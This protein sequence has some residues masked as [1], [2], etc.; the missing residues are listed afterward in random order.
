MTR[1]IPKEKE[2]EGKEEKGRRGE[3]REVGG[4]EER[5]EMEIGWSLVEQVKQIRQYIGQCMVL[6]L[7]WRI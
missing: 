7:P 4:K 5:K 6:N 1:I 3:K 2:T